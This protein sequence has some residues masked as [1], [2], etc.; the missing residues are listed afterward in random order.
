MMRKT[1][2]KMSLHCICYGVV[3]VAF[4]FLLVNTTFAL[5]FTA[6]PLV[7]DDTFS[8]SDGDRSASAKFTFSDDLMSIVLTNTYWG[9]VPDPVH[10]LQ[11]L[12]FDLSDDRMLTRESAILASGSVVLYDD[13][14]VGGIVGGEFAYRGDLNGEAPNGAKHGI[15]GT[16]YGIFSKSDRFP[17]DN[18]HGEEAINGM[19]YGLLS[20]GYAAGGNQAVNGEGPNPKPFILNSVVFNLSGALGLTIDD[21]S[22]VSFEYGTDLAQVSEPATLLLLGSGLIG[23]GMIRRKIKK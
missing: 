14:P 7:V 16:G 9:D 17:G 5:N 8:F 23:I 21:V 10:V 18:L 1:F 19:P 15:S 4:I 20:D 3:A 2:I 6:D 13:A 11:A 22:N 12:W